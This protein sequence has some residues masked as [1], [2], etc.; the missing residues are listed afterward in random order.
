[1]A[2]EVFIFGAGGGGGVGGGSEL[3]V[4]G[5]ATR[6]VKAAQNT[7]WVNTNVTVTNYILSATEPEAPVEGM[8]WITIGDV[9]LT[10]STSSV[11]DNW[12][13]VYPLIA[14]QRIAGK[15]TLVTAEI[16]QDGE[17]AEV[18]SD[19][20][21]F[22]N[23]KFNTDAFGE[24]SGTQRLESNGTFRLNRNQSITHKTPV[25]I[26][27]YSKFQFEIVLMDWGYPTVTIRSPSGTTIATFG[28]YTEA[29]VITAD[30]SAINTEVIITIAVGGNN[31]ANTCTINDVKFVI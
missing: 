8:V 21:F 4:V 1:M 5:G 2:G 28:R 11:G 24:I 16:Y 29:G 14:N 22:E 31:D 10:K 17:W 7:I 9:G 20:I 3:T 30:V 27:P 18:V 12:V 19:L 23:G 26:S 6:P 25:D 13:T 15:W